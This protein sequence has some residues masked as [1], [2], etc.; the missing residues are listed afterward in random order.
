MLSSTDRVGVM[1]VR[2]WIE[3]SGNGLRARLTQTVDITAREERSHTAVTVEGI[4]A[5]VTEWID[6]FL[7]GAGRSDPSKPIDSASRDAGQEP[8]GPVT[9]R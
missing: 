8:S 1:V 9:P 6:A 5:G 2:I 4:L 3:G 7:D